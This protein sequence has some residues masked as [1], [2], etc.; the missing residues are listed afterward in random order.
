MLQEA[1][2]PINVRLFFRQN[3]VR[4]ALRLLL[5]SHL[6]FHVSGDEEPLSNND[7]LLLDMDSKESVKQ[8]IQSHS[9]KILALASAAMPD[10]FTR[11]IE[12]GAKGLVLK[13]QC[14]ETLVK[15]I[16]QVHAGEI[17]FDKQHLLSLIEKYN[18]SDDADEVKLSQ[19]TRREVDVARLVGNGLKN[20]QIAERLFISE[21]TVR[22]HLESIFQKLQVKD[23]VGLAIWSVKIK[24]NNSPYAK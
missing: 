15:A 10:S 14:V 9:S 7:V 11:A 12:V 5:E 16:K 19:L 21:R 2:Q 22:S 18:Q 8:A 23:R 6:E 13:E 4:V 20:R 1:S 17:C 3:I 24:L